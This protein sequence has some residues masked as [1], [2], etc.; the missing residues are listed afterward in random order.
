[1]VITFNITYKITKTEKVDSDELEDINYKMSY[2]YDA[3]VEAS[4]CYKYEGTITFKGS[5][6]TDIDSI[7]SLR[8]GNYD[9]TWYIVSN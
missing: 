5:K 3:D 7:D 6:N 4:E 9:G 1:M 2:Y 8:Y